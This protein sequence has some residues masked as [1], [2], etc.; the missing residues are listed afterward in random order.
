MEIISPILHSDR[1]G[2]YDA[3]P[4][5]LSEPA[6]SAT[7]MTAT[8]VDIA[9]PNNTVIFEDA[10]LTAGGKGVAAAAQEL[11]NMPAGELIINK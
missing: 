1:Y 7:D 4:G 11:I 8:K 2:H 9:N 3:G 5:K 10:F 6:F